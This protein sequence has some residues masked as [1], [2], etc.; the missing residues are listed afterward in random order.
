[1][2]VIEAAYQ[3]TL[4][5]IPDGRAKAG[6]I[7]TGEAA[8]TELLAARA[9]DGRFGPFRFAESTVAGG[10]RAGAAGNR[11]RPGG[12]AEGRHTVRAPRPGSASAAGKPYR[13]GSRAYAADFN[14]V[15]EIGLTTSWA[16]MPDQTAAAN[17]WGLTNATATMASIIRSVASSPAAPWPTTT[18]GSRAC[19]RTPRT[20]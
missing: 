18:E 9:G 7:A 10:W 3:A 15:K 1:M 5:P 13:L 17:Y 20:R 8:A 11:D 4:L 16:Q 14:E 12:L 6:G 2:P 19:T